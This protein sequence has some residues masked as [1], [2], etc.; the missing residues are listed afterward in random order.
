MKR[1]GKIL[2]R[3]AQNRLFVSIQIQLQ[4]HGHLFQVKAFAHFHNAQKQETQNGAHE[5]NNILA[6]RL[7]L[8]LTAE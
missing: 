8:H 6:E 3:L 2:F 1:R 7:I 4:R 5:K